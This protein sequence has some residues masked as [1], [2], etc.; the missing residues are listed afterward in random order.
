MTH[1]YRFYCCYGPFISKSENCPYYSISM[2]GNQGGRG[3]FREAFARQTDPD[4]Y[5]G[6]GGCRPIR[7]CAPLVHPP[8]SP[9]TL[10][11]NKSSWILTQM[12]EST[13]FSIETANYQ[14]LTPSMG[15]DPMA[16]PPPS[17]Q[18]GIFTFLC[19][20][21]P[22]LAFKSQRVWDFIQ[23]VSDFAQRVWAFTPTGLVGASNGAFRRA[24]ER[25]VPF[26]AQVSFRRW[27]QP[28]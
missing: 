20:L 27:T 1:L 11:P 7:C 12:H 3:S 24:S 4:R 19:P 28:P 26:I 14:G 16:D 25:G 23:R 5:G 9:P 6:L 22:F 15:S 21:P 10:K 18:G 8:P 17:C 2:G 13:E